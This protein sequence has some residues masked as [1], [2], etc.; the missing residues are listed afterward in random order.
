LLAVTLGLL[1]FGAMWKLEEEEDGPAIALSPVLAGLA[2][3][4]GIFLL[5]RRQAE[6]LA[7]KPVR[8]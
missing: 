7:L 2:I 4:I 3:E 8:Q 1:A 6:L 5:R